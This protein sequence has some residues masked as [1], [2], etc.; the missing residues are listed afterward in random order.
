MRGGDIRNGFIAEQLLGVTSDVRELT[1]APPE[2]DM[3]GGSVTCSLEQAVSAIVNAAA[4]IILYSL[5]MSFLLR[6]DDLY[7]F[8]GNSARYRQ[9]RNV[10]RYHC[11]RRDHSP[12][13]Y[14]NSGKY[15][16]V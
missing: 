12:I 3:T 2:F 8:C 15:R 13:P 9:R 1:E 7:Y 11:A 5:F 14:G 16:R 10:T 6:V 4:G